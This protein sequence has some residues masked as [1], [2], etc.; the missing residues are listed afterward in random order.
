MRVD[1]TLDRLRAALEKRGDVD[2]RC[3]GGVDPGPCGDSGAGGLAA[4]ITAGACA[5]PVASGMAHLLATKPFVF[6][7]ATAALVGLLTLGWLG[8][9]LRTEHRQLEQANAALRAELESLRS[10]IPNPS[11]PRTSRNWNA[12]GEHD[13]LLRLQARWRGSGAT[14][15]ASEFGGG[16]CSSR[17]T[18]LRMNRT[19]R[20]NSPSKPSF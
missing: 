8:S 17:G 18:A 20:C 1:Q 3:A 7:T 15:F 12:S 13:E 19:R 4:S 11:P 6:G 16:S 2:I 10:S 14:G 5:V 9:R